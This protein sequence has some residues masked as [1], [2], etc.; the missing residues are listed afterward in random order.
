VT[1]Y[2]HVVHFSETDPAG[3]LFFSR[4]FEICHHAFEAFLAERGFPLSRVMTAVD[5]LL[6]L[7]HAEAD[8]AAPL[9]LGDTLRIEVAVERM[10]ARSITFVYVVSTAE[11]GTVA[12]VRHVHAAIDRATWQP[13]KLPEEVR[14]HLGAA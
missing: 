11:R 10:G 4:I 1:V 8:F 14:T 6:P 2:E 3:I 7:V 9:R 12:T 5:W 13:R